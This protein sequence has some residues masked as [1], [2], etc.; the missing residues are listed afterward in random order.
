MSIMRAWLAG[1]G[2]AVQLACLP[3]A[4]AQ[5][6]SPADAVPSNPLK[7][8]YFGE[9]HLHTSYSLD[10]FI[11]GNPNDPDAAYKFAQG[12]PVTLYGGE[13]K[14]LKRPMDFV[15]I[16]DHSEFL[17]EVALCSTLGSAPYDSAAC[18]GIRSFDMMQLV[19][20]A[21]SVTDRKRRADICGADGV[22]CVD[23]IK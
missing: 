22:A 11:F 3:A 1:L 4:L 14:Q 15:A 19:R 6:P 17:G 21:N 7:N 8:A 18:K 2:L 12:Q 9:L 13:T 5:A 16:T 20:I 10:S 23:A